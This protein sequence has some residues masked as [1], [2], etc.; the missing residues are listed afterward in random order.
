MVSHTY[1]L[2]SYNFTNITCRGINRYCGTNN[3]IK[4]K[5]RLAVL[6]EYRIHG[7]KPIIF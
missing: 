1:L 2:M 5:V 4:N 6:Q 7:P 3:K